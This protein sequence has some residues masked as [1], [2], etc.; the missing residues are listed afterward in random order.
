MSKTILA[1]DFGTTSIGVAVGQTITSHASALPALKATEGV[2]NWDQVEK[3]IKEWEPDLFVIGLPFN[4]DGSE[5]EM[6]QKARKFGNRLNGRFAIEI[7]YQD[8][9]L[10]S[11]EAKSR[12]FDKKGFKGLNKQKIDSVSAVIILEGW[13]EEN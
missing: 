7:A 3:L 6:T 11:V 8:E 10:S 1:F 12:L 4:M 13:F 2:P 9:R 5:Q